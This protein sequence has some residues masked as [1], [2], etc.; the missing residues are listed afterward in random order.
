[1]KGI[2]LIVLGV[3]KFVDNLEWQVCCK[4]ERPWCNKV[5][6]IT[7]FAI[8]CACI[9]CG[10]LIYEIPSE[11]LAKVDVTVHDMEDKYRMCSFNQPNLNES[12]VD[13]YK[14]YCSK[15]PGSEIGMT[16]SWNDY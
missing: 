12:Q 3:D 7:Q 14:G 10:M 13:G 4:K 9:L 16:K 8:I 5:Y 1:M 2:I 6:G 15:P 11:M